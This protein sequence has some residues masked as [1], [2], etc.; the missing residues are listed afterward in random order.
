MKPTAKIVRTGNRMDVLLFGFR[1]GVKW[2]AGC[3]GGGGDRPV[4]N[5]EYAISSKRSGL[6]VISTP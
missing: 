5:T 3:S 2:T 4:P 6:S 1:R